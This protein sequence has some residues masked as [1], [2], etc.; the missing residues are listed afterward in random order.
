MHRGGTGRT[1]ASGEMVQ[2][3]TTPANLPIWAMLTPPSLDALLLSSDQNMPRAINFAPDI[4]GSSVADAPLLATTRLMIR[5]AQGISGLTLTATGA[6]S[7]ADVR[8]LFDAMSWPGYDKG[9]ALA[10]NKVLNEADVMPVELT[11]LTAQTAKLLRK[12][13]KRLL[14]TKSGG[15]LAEPE[16]AAELFARLFATIFWQISLSYFDRVPFE[17][18]P[19][20]HIGIVLWCL[21]VAG[22]G[23]F[24]PEDLMRTC[25]VRE[26]TLDEKHPDFPAYAF[27]SRVLRPL[28]WFGLLEMRIIGDPNAPTWQRG[29][30]YRKA[31]LFDRVLRF[32]VQVAKPRGPAH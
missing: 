11:R 21:S 18:W 22:E 26:P 27:E 29:R 25:T 31:A 2:A 1:L 23:W 19:Q 16:A 28:S 15:G 20:N 9:N 17:A 7:R 24:L 13:E 8:A 32:D 30:Q 3:M 4:N 12:R 10:M 14:A 5:R 6:L